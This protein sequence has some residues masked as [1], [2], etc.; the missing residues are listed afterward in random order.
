MMFVLIW[1]WIKL[2]TLN[3]LG[4]KD[5]NM[6]KL[7]TLNLTNEQIDKAKKDKAFKAAL[8]T[9]VTIDEVDEDAAS[10]DS[11]FGKDGSRT[12]IMNNGEE[13]VCARYSCIASYQ[14]DKELGI[15]LEEVLFQAMRRELGF[16]R[17]Y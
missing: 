7:I 17:K 1:N 3:S 2:P 11:E 6:I 13:I 12:I 10:I 8:P 14:L 4:R 16:K 15:N 9:L 5:L